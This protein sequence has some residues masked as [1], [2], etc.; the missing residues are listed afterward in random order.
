[1][2]NYDFEID[3]V[4]NKINSGNYKSVCLQF[5][6]GLKPFSKEVVDEIKK[7]TNT[8]IFIWFGSCF[9]ACDI[10]KIDVELL[11]QFGHNKFIKTKTWK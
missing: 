10:P 1:M 2:E 9:G 8:K 11:I 3:K 4:I 5:P 7:K 6:D